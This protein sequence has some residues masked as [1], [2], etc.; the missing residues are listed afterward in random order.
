MLWCHGDRWVTVILSPLQH[1]VFISWRKMVHFEEQNGWQNESLQVDAHGTLTCS[2]ISVFSVVSQV[3]HEVMLYWQS[4][5]FLDEWIEEASCERVQLLPEFAVMVP[6]WRDLI[7]THREGQMER[8]RHGCVLLP[9][10][11]ECLLAS[12]IWYYSHR[13]VD[14]PPCF[15][16]PTKSLLGFNLASMQSL[17]PQLDTLHSLH[18]PKT[19]KSKALNYLN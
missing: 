6:H 8:S 19:D 14:P 17:D 15:P 18:T 13:Q 4:N 9:W 3:Q 12:L 10:N 5:L 7:S 2:L 16:L 11:Q 1:F